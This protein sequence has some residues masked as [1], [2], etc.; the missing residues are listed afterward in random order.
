[1]KRREILKSAAG[2]AA[3]CVLPYANQVTAAKVESGEA[4]TF[5]NAKSQ[6]GFKHAKYWMFEPPMEFEGLYFD[7]V[8][9]HN[10]VVRHIQASELK[11][12]DQIKLTHARLI[13][14]HP[15]YFS[16]MSQGL[17]CT[18]KPMGEMTI[19]MPQGLKFDNY[20]VNHRTVHQGLER[21][22]ELKHFYKPIPA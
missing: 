22:A 11:Y 6:G 5:I 1:M 4:L 3:L 14:E 7:L 18:R 20:F 21:A 19:D 8:E 10:Y 16:D 2:V 17:V 13:T 12:P 9:Y 15:D